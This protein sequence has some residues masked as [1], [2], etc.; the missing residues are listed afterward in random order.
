MKYNIHGFRSEHHNTNKIHSENSDE[1]TDEDNEHESDLV[2]SVKLARGT[3][4]K[5]NFS[6]IVC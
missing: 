2:K 1:D 6:V 3:K 5:K 4:I